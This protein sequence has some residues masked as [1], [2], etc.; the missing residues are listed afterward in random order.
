[1]FSQG[2]K[3]NFWIMQPMHMAAIRNGNQIGCR[4]A[5]HHIPCAGSVNILISVGDGYFIR[6]ISLFLKNRVSKD[7]LSETVKGSGFYMICHNRKRTTGPI[8]FIAV[9]AKLL[10]KLLISLCAPQHAQQCIFVHRDPIQKP[11][12]FPVIVT[13][14]HRHFD[15]MHS[16]S[17]SWAA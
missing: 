16:S 2:G 7:R 6:R 13:Y 1:M 11:A 14:F 15:P 9:N 8:P 12:S 17:R 5:F 3:E 4:V 10:I